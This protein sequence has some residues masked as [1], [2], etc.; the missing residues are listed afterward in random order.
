MCY[1]TFGWVCSNES[2]FAV[3]E[4]E[5]CPVCGGSGVSTPGSKWGGGTVF[6]ERVRAAS[7]RDQTV[8]DSDQTASDRDQTWADHDQASSDRD[9]RSAHDDQDSADADAAAGGDPV[10]HERT[11]SARERTSRDRESVGH[12]RSETA[13][14]RLEAAAQRDEAAS[15]REEAAEERDRLARLAGRNESVQDMILRGER[16]RAIAAADRARAADDRAKAAADREDASRQRSEAFQAQAEARHDLLVTSTD[17]LTGAL[18][19][20]FGLDNITREIERAR[21]TDDSLTLAFVDIDGLKEVNDNEGH[22]AG[23]GLLRLV[24]DTMRANLRPYDV[25]VR[26]GGDEFLCAFPHVSK[27]VA[28]ERMERIASVLE[29]ERTHHSITFGLAEFDPADGADELIGRADTD[30]LESRRA[31]KRRE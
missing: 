6:S 25:V 27:P 11:K 7:D 23:D 3:R 24:V 9:E 15:L 28:R 12:L 4:V 10:T 5:V 26:Y 19:R 22:Q 21:R 18:T 16:D 2:W 8:S 14:D 20:K 13:A 17:E 31:R 1:K 30:L 29:A